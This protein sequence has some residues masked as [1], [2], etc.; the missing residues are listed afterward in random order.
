MCAKLDIVKAQ[1]LNLAAKLYRKAETFHEEA[2][3][4]SEQVR[5][6]SEK[7]ETK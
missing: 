5:E 4:A 3:S 2:E 1:V 7:N 6:Y